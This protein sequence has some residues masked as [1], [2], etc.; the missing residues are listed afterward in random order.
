VAFELAQRGEAMPAGRPVKFAAFLEMLEQPVF[1]G[2]LARKPDARPIHTDLFEI[3]GGSP[4]I[5]LGAQIV[6]QIDHE[7]GVAAGCAPADPLRFQHDNLVAGAE[8]RQPPCGSEAGEACADHDPVRRQR[9]REL[10][11]GRGWRK[12]LVPARSRQIHRNTLGL[13][14]PT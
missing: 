5:V 1:F 12:Q 10:A 7:A 8:L 2:S 6:R 11:R 13:R 9:L 3:V 14:M 4:G